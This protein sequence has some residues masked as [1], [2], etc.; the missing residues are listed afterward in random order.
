MSAKGSTATLSTVYAL[1]FAFTGAVAVHIH[2]SAIK[3]AGF[4]GSTHIGW[5]VATIYIDGGAEGEGTMVAGAQGYRIAT[6]Q[7]HN[8]PGAQ[9]DGICG[10]GNH[11]VG[12]GVAISIGVGLVGKF[13][14]EEG[15]IRVGDFTLVCI[16]REGTTGKYQRTYLWANHPHGAV[17]P[18]PGRAEIAW[19]CPPLAVTLA[20]VALA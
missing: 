8:H 17:L 4:A 10:V 11:L 14:E 15:S 5:V 12:V 16:D 13:T 19:L 1:G 3:P 6:G 9:A 18:I 2:S 7:I 20:L